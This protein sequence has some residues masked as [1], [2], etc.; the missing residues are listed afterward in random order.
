[1]REIITL[2]LLIQVELIFAQGS[3]N[4]DSL[5]NWHDSDTIYEIH[6][7]PYNKFN[8]VWGYA[9]N[10]REYAILGSTQGTHFFDVTEPANSIEVD[11]VDGRPP[12]GSNANFVIHRDY[13]DFDDYLYMISDEGHGL[14]IADLR[15]LP[16]SVHVV[17]YSWDVL[18]QAHNIFIDSSSARLYVCGGGSWFSVFSLANPLSPE[19]L[20]DCGTDVSYWNESIGWVHDVYV[21]NDTAY[22]NASYKGLFII[23]F[24]DVSN[25]QMIGS[26][27]TYVQQGY[28]HSGWLMPNVPYY[29]MADE[30]EGL[31]VKIIDV[32][33]K[34]NLI[35]TDTIGSNVNPQS[36]PHNLIYDDG[37]LYISYYQ[38]GLYM[39][40][41][42]T[43]PAHPTLVGFYDTS[44]QLHGAGYVGCWGVYPFLPS[45]NVLASDTE[46]G[47]WVFGHSLVAAIP[48]SEK[49]RDTL[50]AF[51]NPVSERLFVSERFNDSR[52]SII[53]MS[54]RPVSHG[55]ICNSLDVSELNSGIYTLLLNG[56]QHDSTL[57][58]IKK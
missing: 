50:L 21:R 7:S 6:Y 3:M 24:S 34:S 45:G 37:F 19:I 43:D 2:L 52:Y 51:P 46:T 41:C 25:P 12:G 22:C 42:K 36:M 56:A 18:V 49:E 17:Y 20:I 11:F 29:A 23:D 15:Y 47:L 9:K 48:D 40:D 4:I 1:M 10:G 27:D 28:N 5:Y 53:D 38:D 39:F 54:G 57:K 55:I 8:E 13:H 26:L 16:D 30:T 33:D 44:T 31:D 58:F 32:S 35:V 14:Q